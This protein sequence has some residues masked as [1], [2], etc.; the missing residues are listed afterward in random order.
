MFDGDLCSGVCFFV[1]GLFNHTVGKPTLSFR[2]AK[3]QMSQLAE[4]A[5]HGVY[6]SR[7]SDRM[8]VVK[9]FTPDR[10]GRFLDSETF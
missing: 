3:V 6:P 9:A 5:K 2:H 7:L 1:N 4:F 10:I 8:R